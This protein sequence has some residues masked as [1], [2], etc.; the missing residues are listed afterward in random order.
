MERIIKRLKQSPFTDYQENISFTNLP[1]NIEKGGRIYLS[2]CFNGSQY[3]VSKAHFYLI[4][5]DEIAVNMVTSEN[6]VIK[7]LE[8]IITGGKV[9]LSPIALQLKEAGLPFVEN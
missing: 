8:S 4:Q 9:K 7:I 5:K 2:A 6:Q 1:V 3:K